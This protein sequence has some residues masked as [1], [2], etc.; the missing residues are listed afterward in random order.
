LVVFG[1]RLGQLPSSSLSAIGCWSSSSTSLN[2][3]PGLSWT[4]LRIV[5]IAVHF[6]V[7]VVLGP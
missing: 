6:A 1:E 3:L 2:R 4:M 7:G 5:R